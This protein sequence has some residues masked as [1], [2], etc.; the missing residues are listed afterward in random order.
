MKKISLIHMYRF[1]SE[2]H[3]VSRTNFCNIF[4]LFVADSN[5]SH[6]QTI[7]KICL[8]N[9]KNS[10]TRVIETTI[11][12]IYLTFFFFKLFIT[13]NIDIRI[14]LKIYIYKRLT[15]DRE[16][17]LVHA[18]NNHSSGAACRHKINKLASLVDDSI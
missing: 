5:I 13:W 17:R 1:A 12:K 11:E 15:R 7:L 10:L 9:I 14:S 2:G 16:S 8:K 6:A 3:F 4:F 18:S